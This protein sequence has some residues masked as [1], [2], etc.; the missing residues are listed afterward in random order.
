MANKNAPLVEPKD[1]IESLNEVLDAADEVKA[2]RGE[3]KKKRQAV[4]KKFQSAGNA[5]LMETAKLLGLV[6]T[7]WKLGEDQYMSVDMNKFDP[8]SFGPNGPT[9]EEVGL[10]LGLRDRF[11]A[12]GVNVKT[13]AFSLGGQI[14]TWGTAIDRTETK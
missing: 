14:A 2:G 11:K 10:F 5:L 12:A 3:A 9:S 7:E 8:K 6:K 4:R 1:K 13:F